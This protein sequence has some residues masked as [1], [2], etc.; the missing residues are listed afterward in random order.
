MVDRKKYTEKCINSLHTDS[1]I[2]LGH[3]PTKVIEGK[4][5]RSIRKIKNNLPNQ[6]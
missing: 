2:R 5:E 1:F 4:I 3:H 6:E